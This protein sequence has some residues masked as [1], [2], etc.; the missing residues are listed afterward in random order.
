MTR[1]AHPVQLERAE[2]T[3]NTERRWLQT[4]RVVDHAGLELYLRD[5]DP[6]PWA[7]NILRE[8]VSY[9]GEKSPTVEVDP[10]LDTPGKIR[11][12]LARLGVRR[13]PA[14]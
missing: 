5:V 7:R 11:S 2:G 12:R 1:F 3:G 6:R 8:L 14:E 13:W 9:I 4:Q 10:K